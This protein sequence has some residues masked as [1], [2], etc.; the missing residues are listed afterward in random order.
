MDIDDAEERAESNSKDAA[1]LEAAL[2]RVV[3]HPNVVHTF[4]YRNVGA[5]AEG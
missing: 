4:D 1:V 3:K 2:M 5:N